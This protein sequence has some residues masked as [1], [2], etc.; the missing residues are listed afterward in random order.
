M[1]NAPQQLTGHVVRA[2]FARGS[3]S[4]HAA[5]ML[6]VGDRQ[7]VLRRQGG[8]AFQDPALDALVGHTIHGTG[9]LAGHTFIMERWSETGASPSSRECP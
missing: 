8:N 4:E 3:K 1:P 2:P 9:R 7:Y 6:V 5:V